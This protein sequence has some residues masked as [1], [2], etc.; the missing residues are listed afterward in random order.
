MNIFY[1]IGVVVVVLIVAG[2]LGLHVWRRPISVRDL[3]R[4][5]AGCRFSR[6][7]SAHQCLAGDVRFGSEA[8]ICSATGQVRFTLNSDCKSGL[9]SE[10]PCPTHVFKTSRTCGRSC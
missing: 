8:A 7:G 6:P 3:L 9:R 1:I 2:Y 4:T 10:P 5:I